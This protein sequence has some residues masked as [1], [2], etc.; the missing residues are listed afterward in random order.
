MAKTKASSDPIVTPLKRTAIIV[1]DMDRSLQFYHGVLGMNVWVQGTAGEELPAM[2]QLLGMPPCKTR[3]VI[4]QSEDVAWG[5]VGLF[6][7][8]DPAPDDD[9][10][11]NIDR[12]NRGEAC[13][14]FHTPDVAKVYRGAREMGLTVLCPP[15]RLDLKQHGVASKE[16]TLRDPNGVLVNFIQNVK[17]NG[18]M[19]LANRFPGLRKAR[20]KSR[21]AP[22]AKARAKPK[23]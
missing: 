23:R 7:L 8:S 16:M 3:W 4:L 6:E 21:V 2:Y 14:V 17:G 22:R 10:H 11:R 5:M 9:T 19:E 12:A 15:L 1:R 13:L 20:L 18:R